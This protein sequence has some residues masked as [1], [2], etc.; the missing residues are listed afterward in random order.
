[1]DVLE[2]HEIFARRTD[3]SALPF[4][5]ELDLPYG[6]ADCWPAAGVAAVELAG[7]LEDAQNDV[8]LNEALAHFNYLFED[9]IVS[10]E[11]WDQETNRVVFEVSRDC[12]RREREGNLASAAATD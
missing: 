5:V 6:K 4:K 2:A 3:R 8:D 7:R 11:E 12:L 9:K 1:M 10:E